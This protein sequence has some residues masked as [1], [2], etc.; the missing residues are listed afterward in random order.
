MHDVVGLYLSPPENAVVF[1]VDEKRSVR[2][3]VRTSARAYRS[4][5][6]Y[7][8][9]SALDYNTPRDG[10]VDRG[11][12]RGNGCSDLVN[13]IGGTDLQEV[14]RFL[15]KVDKTVPKQ[16]QLHIILDNYATRKH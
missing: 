12:G 10:Y 16:Q 4:R 8:V 13:R 5:R 15:K 6:D 7:A 1:S 2:A 3:L 9:R 11:V 14:L